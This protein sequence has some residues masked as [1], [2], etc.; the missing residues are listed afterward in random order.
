MMPEHVCICVRVGGREGWS[1]AREENGQ[2]QNRCQ[3][4]SESMGR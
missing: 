1:G 2:T 4:E 3:R